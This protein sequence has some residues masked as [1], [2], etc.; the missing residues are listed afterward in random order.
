[1]SPKPKFAFPL[2]SIALSLSLIILSG[3]LLGRS[4]ET[5]YQWENVRIDGGGFVTGLEF[6][7]KQADLLYSRTDVGGAFR[8]DGETGRWT[9]LNNDI[10]GLNNEFMHLGVLTMATDPNDPA[11]LFLI[12][13][14]YLWKQSWNPDAILLRSDD[15]GTN[16]ERITLN[17]IK[18]GGNSDGRSNGERLRVHPIEG[19]RLFFGSN[20][21][22][23]WQSQDFG[24][25]WEQNPTFPKSSVHWMLDQILPDTG[26]VRWIAFASEGNTGELLI[27]ED[28]DDMG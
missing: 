20:E 19:N 4:N 2:R 17:G 14:Q 21:E 27:S 28:E 3:N 13:G 22:G 5:D 6:H 1:M 12:T 25:T 26:G 11:K 24:D 9:S 7:P 15:Y 10:G 18:A 16:W 8:W 23:L